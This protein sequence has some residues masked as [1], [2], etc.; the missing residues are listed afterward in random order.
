MLPPG[1]RKHNSIALRRCCA[2]ETITIKNA[3]KNQAPTFRIKLYNLFEFANRSKPSQD[4]LSKNPSK[5]PSK[6]PFKKPTS[7]K[8]VEVLLPL[9]TTLESPE[10]LINYLQ[11]NSL[12]ENLYESPYPKEVAL[13]YVEDPEELAYFMCDDLYPL[14]R[15]SC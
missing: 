15:Q 1:K 12:M 5:T 11:F 8:L 10:S 13:N 2:T 6:S 7:D 3:P 9:K 14:E 4:P